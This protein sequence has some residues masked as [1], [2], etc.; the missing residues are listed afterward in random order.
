MTPLATL[1]TFT[2]SLLLVPLLFAVSLKAPKLIVLAFIAVLFLFSSSTWGQMEAENTV[3]ARGTGIFYFSLLNLL[4]LI[5][6]AA[7]LVRK[8][9]NPN[10]PYLAAPLFP[11]FLAFLFLLASHIVIGLMSGID[12]MDILSYTGI[13]N[14]FNM[15]IF[16]YLVMMAFSHEE[17]KN[18]LLLAI[19]VLAACRS[20]FGLVR[21]FWFDGDSANP[22]RNFEQL[23]IKIFFFDIA[24]N[25]VASLGAFCAAWWLTT[26]GMKLSLLKRLSLLL[27]LALEIAAVALSFRRTSLVGLGLMFCLLLYLLP[28]RRKLPFV[29]LALGLL[30]VAA[31]VFFQQRLQFQDSGD[32]LSSLLYDVA[33]SQGGSSGRFYELFAAAKSIGGN[34]LFGLGT[35]GS[36]S[37]DQEILSYHF[38]KFDFVHSGFG[39]IVLKTGLA[40]LLLFC[41]LLLAYTA[42]YFRHRAALTGNAR[43]I[44]DAGFAGF[45]F[46]IPT[47]LVGTPI[48]EFRS[49]LLI[50]LTLAMPFVAV[51][52]HNYRPRSHAIA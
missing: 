35:W 23:D 33:P 44:A 11:Y 22:Y 5:A 41:A 7:A 17:D 13:I 19:I 10:N 43:L 3:Y 12:L 48:I 16:M 25:F 14:I 39:H 34:W 18:N 1:G 47:L 21:F 2:L 30:S 20:L 52:L 46:W 29:V 51:G 4:L 8:L 28:G 38:G 24:D 26:P 36:F 27:F 49:M 40:G 6:G 15:L 45:L 42:F 50:G 9:A 32:I 31:M 37:G